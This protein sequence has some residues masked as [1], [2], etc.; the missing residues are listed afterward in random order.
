MLKSA[1]EA[2]NMFLVA[3]FHHGEKAPLHQSLIQQVG[4]YHWHYHVGPKSFRI[5]SAVLCLHCD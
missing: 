1:L 5:Y 4:I 3:R 2:A